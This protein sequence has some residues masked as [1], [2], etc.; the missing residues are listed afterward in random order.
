MCK[1]RRHGSPQSK[2]GAKLWLP[3]RSSRGKVDIMASQRAETE[4]IQVWRVAVAIMAYHGIGSLNFSSHLLSLPPTLLQTC[5]LLFA[6][7][8]TVPLRYSQ[9]GITLRSYHQHS[10]PRLQRAKYVG[11]LGTT[12]YVW[13]HPPDLLGWQ[14]CHGQRLPTCATLPCTLHIGQGGSSYDVPTPTEDISS[15]STTHLAVWHK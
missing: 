2:L 6:A 7:R 3:F 1:R 4:L 5:C 12:Q 11:V 9:R 14:S 8:T 10:T 13:K 15:P